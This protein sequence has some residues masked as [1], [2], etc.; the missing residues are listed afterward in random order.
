MA[1]NNEIVSLE[2]AKKEVEVAITRLA[3]MHLSFSK[4]LIEEFGNDKGS[5]LIIKSIMEYGQRITELVNKGG[6]DLPKWGVHS[7]DAYQDEDGRFIVTGCN[8]AKIFKQFNELDLGL[9]Y[10]YVDA[11]KSMASDPMKKLIHVKS[12]ACG[13]DRCTFEYVQTTEEERKNFINR[14]KNWKR[15]DPRL[16]QEL[17]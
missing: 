3:L 15:V 2:E 5:E 12:E 13:D 7:G 10:C 14:D 11:A 6:K 16:Y 9:L 4:V 8:L 17:G 1:D